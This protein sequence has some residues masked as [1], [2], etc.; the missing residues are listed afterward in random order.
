MCCVFFF[1][2]FLLFFPRFLPFFAPNP[3][4]MTSLLLLLLYFSSFDFSAYR[5]PF[6][7]THYTDVCKRVFLLK[8]FFFF[9]LAHHHSA[10]TIFRF[11]VRTKIIKIKLHSLCVHTHAKKMN[12]EG[13]HFDAKTFVFMFICKHI[14]VWISC[15]SD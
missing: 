5:D 11:C 1:S 10:E 6:D 2:F 14:R 15:E 13:L 7:C 8:L 4:M 9:A 3:L 12:V